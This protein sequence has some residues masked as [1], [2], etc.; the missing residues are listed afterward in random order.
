LVLLKGVRIIDL[1]R[2]KF[3]FALSFLPDTL[4][5]RIQTYQ[6]SLPLGQVI[7][8]AIDIAKAMIEMENRGVVHCDIKPANIMIFI[9]RTS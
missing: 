3:Y 7:R 6:G 8:L 5:D 1:N 2:E 4:E 9:K